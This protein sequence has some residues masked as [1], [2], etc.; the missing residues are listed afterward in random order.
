MPNADVSENVNGR[1]QKIMSQLNHV[2]A[3]IKHPFLWWILEG[4]DPDGMSH[5]IPLNMAFI[6]PPFAGKGGQFAQ[7]K[8]STL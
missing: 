2:I 7:R 5:S 6:C 1:G 3:Q 4:I 8:R